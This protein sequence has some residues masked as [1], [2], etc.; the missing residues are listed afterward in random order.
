MQIGAV[1]R[2]GPVNEGAEPSRYPAIRDMACRIE[3]AGLDSIWVYDHLLYRWPGRGTDGIWEC[4]TVL[5]AL[6]QATQRVQIETL[7]MCTP[8][9][10]PAVLAKM[11]STLDEV[12]GGRLILGIGA[13]WHQPEFD[14]FG[15]PFDHRGGRFQEAVEIIRPLLRDGYVDFHGTYY[16]AP[17]CKIIPRGPRPGG[18]P[19]MVAGKGPRMLQLTARHADSWNTAW[20]ADPADAVDRIASVRAACAAEGRDPATLE[21]T[22]GV[23][24]VYPDLGPGAMPNSLQGTPEQVAETLQGFADLGVGHLIVDFA[25]QTAAALD[26]FANAVQ[27]FRAHSASS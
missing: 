18:P 7:V 8:F 9:R 25:P 13:G 12:S 15:V 22:A 14:A 23:P 17:D 20:H 2:L 5:S 19:L 21:I 4:W 3:D 6:A 10:N 16:S 26:R 24:V 1:V 27:L 11:A